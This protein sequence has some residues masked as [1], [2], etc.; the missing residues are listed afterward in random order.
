MKT[1]THPSLTYSSAFYGFSY[2]RSGI[3]RPYVQT[4][5]CGGEGGKSYFRK[6]RPVV[7]S[8]LR[9][10]WGDHTLVGVIAMN[11]HTARET[12]SPLEFRGGEE[13]VI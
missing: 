13:G 6:H 7:F 5:W 10:R 2:L 1:R 9:W 8:R 4:K 11:G 3:L 12:V